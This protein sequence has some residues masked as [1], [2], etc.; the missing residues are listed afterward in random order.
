MTKQKVIVG[1]S[2]GVDSAVAAA[3][4]LAQ[5]YH[6]EALFMK[7]WEEDDDAAYCG[8]AEDLADATAVA[9]RNRASVADVSKARKWVMDQLPVGVAGRS[10]EAPP[11][12][13]GTALGDVLED[14]S[15]RETLVHPG[16]GEEMQQQV[17]ER[18]QTE[19]PVETQQPGLPG[20]PAQRRDGQRDQQEIQ[21]PG[22]EAVDQRLDRIGAERQP[23]HTER[24]EQQ[25]AGRHQAEQ[26]HRNLEPANRTRRHQ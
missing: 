4:L 24:F 11:D 23:R 21:A 20:K 9:A 15:Q 8:A 1:L 14:V 7:N 25:D 16:V 5:D 10:S 17:E 6:V 13:G 18:E 19:H 12:A 3:L 22:A 26:E 2:G